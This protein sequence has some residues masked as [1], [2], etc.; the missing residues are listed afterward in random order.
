MPQTALVQSL[1]EGL[2]LAGGGV[3]G[4]GRIA[5]GVGGQA[6]F[7]LR[8]LAG[9]QVVGVEDGVEDE[10]VGCPGL[11]APHGVVGEEDD[12]ALPDGD[13]HDGGVLGDLLSTFEEARDEE[14]RGVAIAQDDAR[15][16]LRRDH[17]GV[18]ALLFVGQR[19]GFPGLGFRLLGGLGE[20]AAGRTV[21]VFGGAA[22]GRALAF[23]GGAAAAASPPG[24]VADVEDRTVVGVEDRRFR[25]AV[26]D[27][28]RL[29]PGLG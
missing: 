4:A 5:R 6:S 18:V 26:E 27:R 28:G 19:Q 14:V 3:L 20:S 24:E 9:V 29:V 16:F 10:E 25:I 8:L 22:A 13:V 15:A 17:V 7:G 12:V 23:V 2:D 11:A 1:G 21:G